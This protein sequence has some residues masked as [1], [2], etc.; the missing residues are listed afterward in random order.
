MKTTKPGDPSIVYHPIGL[1]DL[2]GDAFKTGIS[3]KSC[4]LKNTTAVG[5]FTEIVQT[6]FPSFPMAYISRYVT[7]EGFH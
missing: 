6:V 4:H 3:W 5:G 1:L 7:S 2:E